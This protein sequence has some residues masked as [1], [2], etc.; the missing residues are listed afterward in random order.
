MSRFSF[1]IYQRFQRHIWNSERNFLQP[2]CPYSHRLVILQHV[3]AGLTQS[4][5]SHNSYRLR[6]IAVPLP[7]DRSSGHVTTSRCIEITK[8]G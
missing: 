8:R 5:F 4:I 7:I 2:V 1:G 3:L 6:E